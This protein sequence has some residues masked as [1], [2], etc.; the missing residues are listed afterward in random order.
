[1]VRLLG[2]QGRRL[3]VGGLDI[4]D[5]TPLF[6]IKPYVPEFDAFEDSAAGWLD[7]SRLLDAAD[8]RF[9]SE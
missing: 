8:E 6:D 3:I 2:R 1:M 7:R 5:G 4:L 9:S